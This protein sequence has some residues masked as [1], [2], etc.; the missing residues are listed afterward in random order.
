M[1]LAGPVPNR[2]GVFVCGVLGGHGMPRCFSLGAALA[3]MVMGQG[4]SEEYSRRYLQR[5][6]VDRV[7]E[8]PP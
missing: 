3:R 8:P 7:F 5:C 6:R 4:E 2:D 1:P